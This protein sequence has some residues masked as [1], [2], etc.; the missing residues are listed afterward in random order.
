[1]VCHSRHG[2]H[3]WY[4]TFCEIER[5]GRKRKMRK[6]KFSSNAAGHAEGAFTAAAPFAMARKQSI[7]RVILGPT[8]GSFIS[9]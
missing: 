8:R 3:Y 2:K 5:G 1:M 6:R 7:H 4:S 9:G